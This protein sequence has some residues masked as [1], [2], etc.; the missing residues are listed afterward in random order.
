MIILAILF[1]IL[2][3]E[4]GFIAAIGFQKLMKHWNGDKI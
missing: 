2:A 3:F 1:G 4:A